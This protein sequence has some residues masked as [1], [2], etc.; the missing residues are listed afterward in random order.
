MHV[1][2]AHGSVERYIDP[3]FRD[4]APRRLSERK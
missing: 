1:M 2:E 4:G 3:E